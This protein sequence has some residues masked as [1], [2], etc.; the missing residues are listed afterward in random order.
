VLTRQQDATS[1][2]FSIAMQEEEQRE[3]D[4]NPT[5]TDEIIGYIA[6]EEN[7]GTWSGRRYHSDRSS[8]SFDESWSSLDFAPTFASAPQFFGSIATFEGSDPVTLRYRQPSADNIQIRLQEDRSFDSEIE[9]NDEEINFLAIAGSGF[10][11]AGAI[12]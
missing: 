1:E 2:G 4:A 8:K 10:L 12:A 9:H 3:K 11:E 6:L 5:H 7:S